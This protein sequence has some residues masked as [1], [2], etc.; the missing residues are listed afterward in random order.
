V[1]ES[2]IFETFRISEENRSGRCDRSTTGENKISDGN[3]DFRGWWK[4][5]KRLT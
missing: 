4:A 5:K 2:V 1:V 3:F